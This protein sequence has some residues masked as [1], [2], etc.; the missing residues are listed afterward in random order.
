MNNALLDT[1]VASYIFKN[2]S[3]A[4]AYLRLLENHWPFISFI[5]LGELRRWPIVRN[6]GVDRI[7]DFEKKLNLY[8]VIHSTSETCNY[9]SKI[10]SIKGQPISYHDGW[11]AATA[12][13]YGIPLATNNRKDFEN[14]PGLVLISM[15]VS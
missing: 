8:T 14:I 3:R 5:T 1:D 11:I 13:E 10:T 2:D 7:A 9:W 15:D 4:V 12:I 6:W